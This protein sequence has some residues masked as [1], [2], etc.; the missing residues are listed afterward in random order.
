MGVARYVGD[1]APN[2]N[3]FRREMANPRGFAGLR[4]LFRP[5]SGRDRVIGE[6]GSEPIILQAAP[7]ST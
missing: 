1:E 3:R 6:L 5:S 2:G 4:S 7:R